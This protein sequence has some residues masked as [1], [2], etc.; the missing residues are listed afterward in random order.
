[1]DSQ[2]IMIL[3]LK[4]LY[5]LTSTQFPAWAETKRERKSLAGSSICS[6]RRSARVKGQRVRR[7]GKRWPD[8]SAIRPRA[9]LNQLAKHSYGTDQGEAKMRICRTDEGNY[10]CAERMSNHLHVIEAM[11]LPCDG[12]LISIWN[13]K[14]FTG[15]AFVSYFSIIFTPNF[16][17]GPNLAAN[18]A[19]KVAIRPTI[20]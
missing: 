1:M 17:L 12:K 7:A 5:A 2:V 8:R 18:M 13:R 3:K 19:A 10:A 16:T 9:L 11:W 20:L 14:W 15:Y 6:H 4:G